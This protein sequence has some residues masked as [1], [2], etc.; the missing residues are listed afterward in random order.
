[1]TDPIGS[2]APRPPRA[3]A[4]DASSRVGGRSVMVLL[5]LI[6]GIVLMAAGIIAIRRRRPR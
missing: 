2:P 4:G 6:L 3:A 5:A 1:M